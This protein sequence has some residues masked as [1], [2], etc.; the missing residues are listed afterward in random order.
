MAPNQQIARTILTQTQR[1]LT[2]KPKTC[3]KTHKNHCWFP[4]HG[5]HRNL[6]PR[7]SNS[8]EAVVPTSILNWL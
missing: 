2:K 7:A 1:N 4:E 5:G 6:Q 8:C 3:P